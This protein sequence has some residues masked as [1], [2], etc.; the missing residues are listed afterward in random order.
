MEHSR[1]LSP[2]L[3]FEFLEREGL[4]APP[5]GQNKDNVYQCKKHSSGGTAL[6]PSPPVSFLIYLDPTT[7]LMFFFS[8]SPFQNVASVMAGR[9]R[10]HVRGLQPRKPVDDSS[11]VHYPPFPEFRVTT[12]P[13]GM[14]YCG[15]TLVGVPMYRVV[16]PNFEK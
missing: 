5:T 8:V 4:E 15:T 7:L 14:Y 6:R 3:Q 10:S 2:L 13:R 11:L 1:T 12:Q 16:P 9:N